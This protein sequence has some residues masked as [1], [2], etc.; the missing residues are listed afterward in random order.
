MPFPHKLPP[1]Q[2]PEVCCQVPLYTPRLWAG[3]L[4]MSVCPWGEAQGWEGLLAA[5]PASLLVQLHPWGPLFCD[6]Y[7]KRL[8]IKI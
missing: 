4:G 1:W 2:G 6:Y 8:T 5:A 3:V 7:L